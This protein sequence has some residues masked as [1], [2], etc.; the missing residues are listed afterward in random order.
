MK[1][2]RTKLA[3]V[4]ITCFADKYKKLKKIENFENI[5]IPNAV[6]LLI[7]KN[8]ALENSI[9]ATAQRLKTWMRSTDVL[10]H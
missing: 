4:N 1:L 7:L 5:L 9:F 10:I 3:G 8:P 2:L 6:V